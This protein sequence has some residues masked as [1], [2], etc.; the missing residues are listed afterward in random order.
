MRTRTL[1]ESS[2]APSTAISVARSVY[3]LFSTDVDTDSDDEANRDSVLVPN[4]SRATTATSGEPHFVSAGE[5]A[6]DGSS[7]A[8]RKYGVRKYFRPLVRAA[9]RKA[10]FHLL[11][12]NFPYALIVWIYL[13][14]GTLVCTHAHVL[15]DRVDAIVIR[16]AQHS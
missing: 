7:D 3:S 11:V 8:P 4:H 1:S 13:F 5:P 10:V 12:L 16:L 2:A 15:L 14:V 9:Y 6:S